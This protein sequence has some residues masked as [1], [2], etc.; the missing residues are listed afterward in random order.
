M[1]RTLLRAFFTRQMTNR[2]LN[3]AISGRNISDKFTAAYVKG[4]L[5]EAEDMDKR[6]KEL[7]A[8]FRD[9]LLMAT[10]LRDENTRLHEQLASAIEKINHLRRHIVVTERLSYTEV[11]RIEEGTIE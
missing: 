6:I 1:L 5:L 11:A 4:R 2:V 3:P 7:N 8:A 9:A 10:D